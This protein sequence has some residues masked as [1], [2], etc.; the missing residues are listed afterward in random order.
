MSSLRSA[1]HT[2]A[3]LLLLL[4]SPAFGQSLPR[5]P[6][7]AEPGRTAPQPVLPQAVPQGETV[8]LPK[9]S[10]IQ[11]PKGS[12]GFSFTLRDVE[13]EGA[14]AFSPDDL[15]PLYA[16]LVGQTVTVAEMFKVASD[17]EVRYRAAGFITTRVIVPPQ[18][19]DDG[20]FRIRVVEGFVADIVYPD[21]I[22]PARAAVASLLDPLRDLRPINVADVERSLLLA[23]DL[24]GMTVKATL[25]PSP[26]ALGGSVIV[27]HQERKAFDASMTFDNRS[28]PY[29]GAQE[30][31]ANL[32]WNGFASHADQLALIARVSS[33]V[34]REWLVLGSYRALLTGDGLML[35]LQSSFARS[36]PGE[37]LDPLQV[38]S[39]VLSEQATLTYPIIRSRLENLHVFGEFEFRDVLTDFGPIAFNRD[40][41]RILRAGLDYDRADGWNGVTA[42]R[43]TVHQGLDI[44]QATPAGS[45]LASRAFGRA[46]YTKFTATV[47]RIQSLADDLSLVTTVAGQISNKPLLASEQFALGGPSFARAYDDGEISG[48]KGW[49][50][51]AELRYTVA[52]PKFVSNGAEFYVYFDGGQV[53]SES[54]L[55]LVGGTALTS[56]GGGV[57]VNPLENLS[58]SLE[59]DVPLDH[60]VSTQ[61]NK[62]ARI[63]FSVTAR[64]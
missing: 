47:T 6:S 26:T 11:A 57:R 40:N 37:E 38:H 61:R 4:A 44:F 25:E 35:A 58:A 17:L 28:S 55:P 56:T 15:R 1:P 5:L 45:P 34:Y 42:V 21:D 20:R 24:P 33:P 64:Y 23:G 31:T 14:T 16:G 62:A 59:A 60:E 7:G 48:D 12:E 46:V 30:W 49:A 29:V 3:S 54:R 53:W 27:V 19:I 51:S 41:L 13:I 52:I 32:A 9:S 39:R 50:G 43:G 18:T 10:A 2:A 8:E 36:Q 22:G 63:F